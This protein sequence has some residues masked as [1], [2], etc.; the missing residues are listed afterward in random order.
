MSKKTML[1]VLAGLL[2]LAMLA[3]AIAG[4][5]R[6]PIVN[7]MVAA[8]VLPV[9]NGIT[10]FGHG[11][12]GLRGY[13]KAM[14]VLQEE[15][16]HLKQENIELR[17]SN[18]RMASL[19]AENKQLRSLLD[20]KEEHT[21][22]TLVGAKVI[23]RNHGAL[24]DNIYI[25]AGRDKGVAV[26]MAVVNG[27]L[28]GIVD[29]VYANYS[30]VLLLTSSRCKVG[31]RVMRVSSRAVGVVGGTGSDKEELSLEHIVREENLYLGDIIVTSGYSGNHPADILIGK[32]TKKQL[33]PTG[34][35]QQGIV[36]P[37]AEISDVEQVLVITKFS[38]APLDGLR[39]QGGLAK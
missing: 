7:S 21:D 2:T 35:L 20:Y 31:A 16:E 22:Q 23:G 11:L 6:F 9:E 17:N 1:C 38:P 13:W 26:D 14:T 18:I 39:K 4:K 34:L 10:S 3:L 32:V 29:E 15:N 24:R 19:Y 37:T 33:D 28:V 36:T 25:N 8:I 27:G 12:D 5:S 30:R